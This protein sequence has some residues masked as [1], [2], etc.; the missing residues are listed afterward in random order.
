MDSGTAILNGN[1]TFGNGLTVIGATSTAAVN[2]TNTITGGTVLENFATLDLG[3]A[4]GLGTTGVLIVRAELRATATETIDNALT[5]NTAAT[6]AAAA[7]KTLT[8]NN[9]NWSITQTTTDIQF[10]SD[11]DTG[12][13]V[14]HTASPGTNDGHDILVAGGTLKG[15]DS[16]FGTF[17]VNAF[18]TTVNAG[19][20]LDLGGASATINDLQGTGIVTSSA[21]APTLT[22]TTD[23]SDQFGNRSEAV[24]TVLAG[25]LSVDL[26]ST[27]PFTTYT[28][29]A[30]NV[31][32]GTTTVESGVELFIGNGGTTGRSA[33]HGRSQQWR[34]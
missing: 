8:L 3:S 24:N 12:T 15:G 7:G 10:G 5:L 17:F 23:L 26:V 11:S 22:L 14:W 31:Y 28:F 21:G 13:I 33:R 19:A 18:E 25:S 1:N 29:T 4:G 2:G 16:N 9:G 34:P 27:G 30:N 20:K 6:I 32:S